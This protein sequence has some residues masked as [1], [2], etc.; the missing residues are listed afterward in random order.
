MGEA[1]ND[2]GGAADPGINAEN[3]G[4]YKESLLQQI[5]ALPNPLFDV[6]D[7][8]LSSDEENHMLDEDLAEVNQINTLR[9]VVPITVIN[10]VF[11][12]VFLI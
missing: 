4:S 9:H 11:L 2:P 5:S 3:Q 10:F 7:T 6:D 8:E 1:N 12:N